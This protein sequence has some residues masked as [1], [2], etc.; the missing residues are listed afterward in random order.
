MWI[1]W[2]LL[3]LFS[4]VAPSAFVISPSDQVNVSTVVN[5]TSAVVDASFL[6]MANVSTVV[7][8]TNQVSILIFFLFGP[9]DTSRRRRD[10]SG[11]PAKTTN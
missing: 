11:R 6:P 3:C 4:A 8:A 1:V 2:L 9:S 5:S 7:N 10:L